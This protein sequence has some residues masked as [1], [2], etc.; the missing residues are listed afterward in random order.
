[1][2]ACPLAGLV[3]DGG[4]DGGSISAAAQLKAMT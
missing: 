3:G 2:G 4:G 1:M